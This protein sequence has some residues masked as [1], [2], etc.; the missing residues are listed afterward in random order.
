VSNVA[1][2]YKCHRKQGDDITTLITLHDK[3]KGKTRTKD[4]DLD[5]TD[6]A[7]ILLITRGY[8]SAYSIWAR[9]K[10]YA[11]DKDIV[12]LME[13]E[14]KG[15]VM[16]YKNINKRIIKLSKRGFLEE[17]KQAT[18]NVPNLHGRKDYK[19]TQEGALCLQDHIIA[20]PD[21]IRDIVGYLIKNQMDMRDFTKLLMDRL[22]STIHSAEVYRKTIGMDSFRLEWDKEGHIMKLVDGTPPPSPSPRKKTLQH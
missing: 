8:S 6:K 4:I 1:Y 14:D 17:I 21:D 10:K 7:I 5:T 11:K 19:L 2:Y 18:P 13:G 12:I 16:T 22:T 20:N 15:S 9:M 3:G